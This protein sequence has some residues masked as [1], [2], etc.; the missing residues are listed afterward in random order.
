MTETSPA[1]EVARSS[2]LSRRAA[3]LFR[4]IIIGL[5]AFLSLVDL[6]ATQSILPS[7]AHHY[8]VSPAAMG[9]ASNASAFG[10]AISGLAIGFFSSR[11]DRRLGILVSLVL[12]AI[13][14]ALL[15]SAP[16]LTT[17]TILRVA[18]GLCMAAAFTLTLAYLGEHYSAEDSA[19]AFAAYITGN[20]SSNLIG[21]F[22]SAAVADHYGIANCFYFFAVLNLLGA[23]LVFFTVQ[24]APPM[25][26]T[27]KGMG[28]PF[29]A[30]LMHMRNPALRA[31]FAIGFCILF[32]FIGTFTYVNFVLVEPPFAIGMMTLGFVYFVFL[33]SIL[34]TPLAGHAVKR[35]GTRTTFWVALGVAIAGLPLLILPNLASIMAGMVLVGVGTFFAQACATGF[36]GR[37]AT[38]DRGSASGLYLACYFFGGLVGA[39]VLGQVFDAY[40]WTACV[41]G[42]GIALL[43]A[44][45]LAVFLE[46]PMTPEALAH[47][48]V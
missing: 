30:W 25:A 7:L 5:T 29:E 6:F 48:Q 37:A 46:T 12:L 31:S 44:A 18:Q 39:A 40:G 43:V 47:Q 13:P 19:S 24:Q 10:M 20:V 3:T 11:I 36:V 33:P 21:R 1:L 45:F 32:A 14:T 34:T 9:F 38:S 42:I 23:L 2:E 8:G 15:A 4:S 22:V 35:F 28:S 16:D 41:I 27:G 26:R 17:F